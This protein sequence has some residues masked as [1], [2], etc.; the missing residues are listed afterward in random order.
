MLN[1]ELKNRYVLKWLL[2]IIILMVLP[3]GALALTLYFIFRVLFNM[4]QLFNLLFL[5]FLIFFIQKLGSEQGDL[6]F[7]LKMSL[8]IV[9]VIKGQKGFSFK[10]FFK[11]FRFFIFFIFFII[12]HS[13]FISYNPLYSLVELISFLLL[14]LFTYKGT[15]SLP[16]ERNR[17]FSELMAIYLGI[18]ILSLFSFFDPSISYLRNGIGFQGISVHPNAFGIVLAPFCSYVL[19]K[20]IKNQQLKYVILF[21][22]SFLLVFLSQSRTSVLAVLLGTLVYFI[23][24]I[25][26][27][28][29]NIPKVIIFL[30]SSSLIFLFYA[31][32][33]YETSLDFLNKANS[34]NLWEGIISSRQNLFEKQ[35]KNISNNPFLGIGFK[36]ISDFEL[37]FSGFDIPY[38][39]GNSLTATIEEIG[40]IGF[41]L[42]LILLF[43]IMKNSF[44]NTTETFVMSI[45]ALFTTLGEA[46][47]FSV[48]GAGVLIWLLIFINFHNSKK[49]IPQ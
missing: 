26:I 24:T 8:L 5:Y 29:L 28:S 9:T 3:Y 48:G 34:N 37:Q 47:I 20:L 7:Y 11:N 6:N 36:N 16:E 13:L 25:R 49:L 14:I 43:Q 10:N 35:F 1:F 23:L 4:S 15:F 41:I 12:F 32:S 46:T 22:V 40:I 39:K 2:V 44:S 31:S 18:I 19:V 42:F 38:E 45:T 17:I 33:F 21:L 30:L 27:K